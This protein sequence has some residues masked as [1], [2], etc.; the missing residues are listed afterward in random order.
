MNN[1]VFMGVVGAAGGRP[2]IP[3]GLHGIDG[4]SRM[5][6]ARATRPYNGLEDS[7]E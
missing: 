1:D 3:L 7:S 5:V 4:V 6:R 2:A